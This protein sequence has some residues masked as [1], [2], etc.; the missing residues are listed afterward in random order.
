MRLCTL[1]LAVA[2]H[3]GRAQTVGSC[4][5]FP[6]DNIWNTRVDSLPLDAHSATYVQT[7]GTSVALH[8]DFGSGLW[9]GGPIGIPFVLVANPPKV[10]VSFDYADESDPGPYPI[11]PNAPIEGG[12]NSSGDRHVLVV[13]QTTCLLYEM[14]SS[15]PQPDGSWKAGSGAI[16]DLKSDALRPAGWTSADAAGLPVLP[17]LL[18]YDEVASGEIKHAIR[19][20][21]P[22]TQK[23]YVWPARH[24]ASSLTDSRYPP[25]G[26]RFRLKA[27]F[28]ISRYSATNQIILRALQQYGMILADNGSAWY[29]G[30]APD[31]RWDNEDLHALAQLQGSDF[32]VV[33]TSGLMVTSDSAQVKGASAGPQIT[34]VVNSASF[35]PALAAGAWITIY[36]SNLSLT[37]RSWR[38]DEIVAG[39]L[40][41]QLDGVSVTVNGT[42]AAVAYI[43]PGQINAQAPDVA[44]S[45]NAVVQV[46]TAKGS[47]T[48]T[49]AI[50]ETAPALFVFQAGGWRYAAAQHASDY[51]LAAP[52]TLYTG[53]APVQAGETIILYGTG[54]GPTDPPVT[55]GYAIAQPA[56]LANQVTVS[57][58]GTMA[59]VLWAGVSAAGLAQLNVVV[60]AGLAAGDAS[61]SVRTAG[62]SVSQ[63]NVFLAVGP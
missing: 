54:F 29:L 61:V 22:Q 7:I 33:D 49:A 25:M 38:A 19:F 1:I 18:R 35:Q 32:E 56:P 45:P 60:P 30:G 16:F 53:S 40:P 39:K 51:S 26:L 36:G 41:Q 43:S 5:V 46:T 2:L 8:P 21:V 62:G 15:Y 31:D 27:G 48:F 10:A 59:R 34:S 55:A 17:G 58:G 3:W 42:A 6:A 52:A 57:I 14:W 63:A 23:A 12:S 50:G 44:V 11:P 24:Y 20:T 28:D 4:A 47:A 37:A 13:D 9:D